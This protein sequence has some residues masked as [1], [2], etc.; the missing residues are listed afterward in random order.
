[1]LVSRIASKMTCA[2]VRS[3]WLGRILRTSSGRLPSDRRFCGRRPRSG[4]LSRNHGLH[5]VSRASVLPAT[6]FSLALATRQIVPPTVVPGTGDLG[7]DEAIDALVGNHPAALLACHPAGDLLGRPTACEPLNDGCSQAPIAFQARSLPAPGPGLLLGAVDLYP[8]WAPRL[9][10]S[11][12]ETVDG[13]RSRAAAICR[14]ELPLAKSR[15]IS[16][17]SSNESWS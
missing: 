3:G 14:T 1:M 8:T 4:V 7:I 17:R 16:H 10:F 13:E 12:R 9:R 15:A 6:A 2:R 5:Q 11:S